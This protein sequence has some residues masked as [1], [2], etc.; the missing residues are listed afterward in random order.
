MRIRPLNGREVGKSESE[1][2]KVS[3]DDPHTLQAGAS[4]NT[5]SDSCQLCWGSFI[6]ENTSNV[7]DFM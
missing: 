4:K 7:R 2:V 3:T 6:P 1:A 5:F